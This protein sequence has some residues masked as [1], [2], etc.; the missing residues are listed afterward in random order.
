MPK[1]IDLTAT[2]G[3]ETGVIGHPPVIFTPIHTH[4]RYGRSNTHISL[5]AILD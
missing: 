2:V 5:I 1:I 4:E 3:T